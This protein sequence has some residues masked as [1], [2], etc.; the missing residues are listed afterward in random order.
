MTLFYT[1]TGKT[2][3][4]TYFYTYTFYPPQSPI[5]WHLIARGRARGGAWK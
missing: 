2:L 3:F 4:Y 1:P 5:Q